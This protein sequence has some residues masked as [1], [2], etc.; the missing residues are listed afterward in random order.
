[1]VARVDRTHSGYRLASWLLRVTKIFRK[2]V[3]MLKIFRKNVTMLKIFWKQVTTL[4]EAV[5]PFAAST[6]CEGVRGV[7]A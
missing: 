7:R 3:A 4:E 2:N 6:C 5:S 1:M